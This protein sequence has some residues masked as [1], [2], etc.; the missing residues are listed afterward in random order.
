ME[1]FLERLRKL[2]F[3]LLAIGGVFAMGVMFLNAIAGR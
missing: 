3:T 2:L 1:E